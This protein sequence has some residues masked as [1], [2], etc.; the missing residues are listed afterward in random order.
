MRILSEF[1]CFLC[2]VAVACC[3]TTAQAGLSDYNSDQLIEILDRTLANSKEYEDHKLTKLR[4]LKR[5]LSASDDLEHRFWTARDLYNEYRNFDSDSAL[6]YVEMTYDLAS[7]IGRQRWKDETD[8]ERCYVYTAS[9]LLDRAQAAI[10]EIEEERLDTTLYL[11]F[12]EQ[13]LFL[14]THRDQYLGLN[15]L[16]NPYDADTEKMLASLIQGLSPRNPQYCWFVGWYSLRGNKDA[17]DAIAKILPVIR[18]SDFDSADDAKNAYILSRLY[19]RI[20]DKENELKYLILSAIAD[21]KIDNKEIASLEKIAMIMYDRHD[22]R[23]A[24]EYIRS[25]LKAADDFK[26]RVRIVSLSELQN[27]IITAYQNESEKQS[28]TLHI[29]FIILAIIAVLLI[30]LLLFSIFQNRKLRLNK[31]A[32]IDSKQQLEKHIDSQKVLENQLQEANAA[33]Q[34]ANDKLKDM[35][36]QAQQHNVKLS[37]NNYAKER[38]IADIF[39]ICSEYINKLDAYRRNIHRLL[40]DRK[41]EELNRSTCNPELSNAEIKELYQNFDKIFLSLYPNFVEDFN[42]LLRPDE[43]IVLK[44]GELLN[45]ELRIYALVRLGLTDSPKIAQFLHCS[46]RTVYNTRQRIRNRAAVPK[47][48]FVAAVR[49]LSVPKI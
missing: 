1:K 29:Y 25:C 34:T 24:N 43:R 12:K 32:L 45:T 5:G 46:V 23:R 15:S 7:R 33:L 47:E 41:F 22:L 36:S 37:E 4:D 38:Y 21:V 14:Y 26:N 35:Y 31:T 20:G 49:S 10:D 30:G 39:A 18:D 17:R 6:Y 40:V 13:E 48:S 44:K 3:V 28:R 27:N 19:E 9:G 8:I 11:M 2:L 16:E 42:T